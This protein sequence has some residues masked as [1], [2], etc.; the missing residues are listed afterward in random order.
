MPYR[1]INACLCRGPESVTRVS[2]VPLSA[3]TISHTVPLM[4]SG[5]NEVSMS[6]TIIL[7]NNSL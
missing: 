7:S 2:E 4:V 5:N 6:E 3:H 1:N